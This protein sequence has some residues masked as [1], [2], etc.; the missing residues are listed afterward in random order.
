[1]AF[2]SVVE[3][4]VFIDYPDGFSFPI[5]ALC[6]RGCKPKPPKMPPVGEDWA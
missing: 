6:C 1:M 5:E 4:L 2:K 3:Y